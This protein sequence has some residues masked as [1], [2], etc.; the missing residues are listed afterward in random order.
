MALFLLIMI[1]LWLVAYKIVS[2]KFGI[3]QRLF[4]KPVSKLQQ[5]SER[6]LLIFCLIILTIIAFV[7]HGLAFQFL[8]FAFTAIL[9]GFRAFMEWKYERSSRQ[10]MMSGISVFM[11][12]IF[13]GGSMIISRPQVIAYTHNAFMY[14]EC[15]TISEPIEIEIRGQLNHHIF[16]GSLLE[17]QMNVSEKEFFLTTFGIGNKK[18]IIDRVKGK[19]RRYIRQHL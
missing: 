5:Q 3:K 13:W 9:L 11:I 4:Y 1:I 10:Y 17:G 8:A 16:Y 2:Q 15:G 19:N 7:Y 18:S 6:L 14:S 12:L